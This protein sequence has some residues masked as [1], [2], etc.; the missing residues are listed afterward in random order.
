MYAS[1]C[2]CICMLAS[3]CVHMY[4]S[5]RVCIS[6]YLL[7]TDRE[8]RECAHNSAF[9]C[10]VFFFAAATLSRRIRPALAHQLHELLCIGD[11]LCKNNESYVLVL[12]HKEGKKKK[13]NKKTKN[14]KNN[15]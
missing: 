4:A 14:T 10:L 5:K 3:V 9:K 12:I 11:H 7:Q 13:N 2:V 6:I 8:A 15:T 1:K